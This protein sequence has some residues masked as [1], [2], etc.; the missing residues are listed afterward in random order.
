M[1]LCARQEERLVAEA[2]RIAEKYAV[3]AVA[4]RA[5]VSKAEDIVSVGRAAEEEF[6]GV[7]I[8]INNAGTG[9]EET[10]MEAADE[11][12]QAYWDLHVMAAVRTTRVIVPLMR[13]RG[14]G[15]IINNASICAKQPL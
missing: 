10:I 3:S 5:D 11:K 14:G 1:L 9:S 15:V 8:L 12:W 7:D 2:K 4:V 13:K 6:G